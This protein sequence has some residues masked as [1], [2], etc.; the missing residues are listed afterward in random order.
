[1]SLTSY[2]VMGN[3]FTVGDNKEI[4]FGKGKG[5][6]FSTKNMEV[7]DFTNCF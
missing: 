2:W 5:R 4:L 3:S 1:M 6:K 7:L